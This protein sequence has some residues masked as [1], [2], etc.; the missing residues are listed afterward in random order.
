MPTDLPLDASPQW[1]VGLVVIIVILNWL[2]RAASEAS[3]SWAK[4]LGPLGRRWRNHGIARQAK[5]AAEHTARMADLEDMT[6]QRDSLAS[7]LLT[8]RQSQETAF[9]Y[10]TY[11]AAWHREVRLQAAES[12]CELPSHLSFFRWKQEQ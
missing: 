9:D 11:D 2:G 12:G 1:L 10:L 5:R 8:C 7:A 6:R 3:E 4:L